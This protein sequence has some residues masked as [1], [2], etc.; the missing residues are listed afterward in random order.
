MFKRFFPDIY[1]DS[2]FHIQY[3]KLIKEN[4]KGLVFDIDNTL[5]PFDIPHPT[6]KIIKLFED[7]KEMGFKICL[8]SN[9][10]HNRVIKFNENL[11]LPAVSKARKPT[12]R[13]INEAIRLLGL[14]PTQVVQI[15]DQV[16]TDV[17]C[18]NRLGLYT[19]LVRPVAERDEFTV[20]I[21][22]GVEK[23]VINIYEKQVKK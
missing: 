19:V 15:G 7:L 22:R 14:N 16:F 6:E 10:N 23:F 8:L 21:K 12:L 5:V 2:I 4:K 18:G 20:K 3:E 17:W 11:K 9:N 1:V 13:G